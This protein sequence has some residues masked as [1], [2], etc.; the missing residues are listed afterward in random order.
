MNPFFTQ[1][2]VQRILRAVPPPEPGPD[3]K[4]TPRA[5][6]RALRAGIRHAVV[7]VASVLLGAGVA[8]F[9]LKSFLLPSRFLDGGVTGISLITNVV[10]GWPVA[11]LIVLV[12]LPFLVLA[13]GVVSRRF[14]AKSAMG[15]VGLGLAVA[16]LPLPVVTRDPL[17]VAA[18]GGMFLGGGIGLAIRGGAILDG[19][20]VLAIFLS[21]RSALSVGSIILLFNLGIFAVAAV[22]MSVEV[23][24]YAVLTY[25]VAAK[26]V[27]FVIDGMEEYIGITVVTPHSE[28]VRRRITGSLGRGCTMYLGTTGYD[29]GGERLRPINIVYTVIT[30]LELARF[31]AEI[32]AVDPDA[33][34]VMTSV[35]DAVGGVVKKKPLAR[36]H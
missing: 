6:R 16:L 17:L 8:A 1:T 22:V 29:G 19:T 36:L 18:F 13:R 31:R 35:K 5:R 26:A 27:D 25:A 10:T 14:A 9:G 3:G 7:D 32:E 33:F 11:W 24:L 15:V 23:A 20:E 34:V 4:D 30:R 2:I 12:N 28:A 21:R